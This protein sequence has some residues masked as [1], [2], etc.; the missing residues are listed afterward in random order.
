MKLNTVF[1]DLSI[2]DEVTIAMRPRSYQ[3]EDLYTLLQWHRCSNYSEVGTGKSLV[4]YLWAMEKLYKGGGVIVIM[5]PTLIVQYVR[6]FGVIENHPFSLCIIDKDRNTRHDLMDQWDQH[7]S[8]PDVVLMSYQMFV[9]YYRY[10]KDKR[11]YTAV[12]ADEAHCLSNAATK[13]FQAVFMTVFSRNMALLTLTATPCTTELRSAYG[14]IK[15]KTPDAYTSLEQFD[16]LHT[17][18]Q[19]PNGNIKMKQV[20]G[21][22]AIEAIEEHLNRHSVRRRAAEVLSLA[23]P[24]IIEH[25][26]MLGSAHYAL[27][28][29]LLSERMLELGDEILIAKNQ[30]AL[31]QMALQ[32][33][34]NPEAYTESKIDDEPLNALIEIVDSIPG[35]IAVFCHFKATVRKL[36]KAF[37]KLNP[38]LIYGDSNVQDNVDKFLN[39]PT[40]GMAI[41]NFKSGGAGLNLQSE[42]HHTV[43]YEATGSPGELEQALGRTYRQGQTKPVVAW[44]FNYT[45]T[46]SSKLFNKAFDRSGDIKIAMNDQ[47][48]FVDHLRKDLVI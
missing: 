10:F 14:H 8:Y 42:C 43:F 41:L 6:N 24:T 44:V 9:K 22:K 40:C 1:P 32:I 21:Y 18:W 33:I 47:V 30:Q 37:H 12:I 11:K 19:M 23:K 20:A 38:A 28:Q 35:K 48:A 17:I 25:H 39:D 36:N 26:V 16:R 3:L 27:Y 7:N 13:N 31:R 29:R 46:K 4:S 34:T 2:P 15:L 5:P 45:M